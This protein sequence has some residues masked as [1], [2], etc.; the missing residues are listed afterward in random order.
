MTH[1]VNT[2]LRPRDLLRAFSQF[3]RDVPAAAVDFKPLLKVAGDL[4][5]FATE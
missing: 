2:P 4:I 3:D 5:V 1:G